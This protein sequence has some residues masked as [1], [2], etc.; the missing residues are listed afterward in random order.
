MSKEF[1]SLEISNLK[2]ESSGRVRAGIAA[3]HGNV[4]AWD[5]RSHPGAFAKTL[6]ENLKRVKHLWNHNS[7]MPP[8]ASITEIKEIGID[9]IP[10]E[11]LAKFQPGVI[12]GGLKVWREYYENP[13][14]DWVL[15][16]IDKGDITEMSYAYDAVKSEY[17]DEEIPTGGKRRVRD[18]LEVK[19]YETSDVLWGMNSATSANVK[20]YALEMM[21]LGSIYQQIQLHN[22]QIKAGRRNSESDSVLISQIHDLAKSLGAVC[23]KTEKELEEETESQSATTAKEKAEAA[24]S[25]SLN[26]NWFELQKSKIKTLEF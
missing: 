16:G 24:K 8:I 14:A 13:L 25:T 12:T 21:P 20:G 19:L 11:I 17:A 4:D 2:A 7:S 1:K 3:V 15:E 23:E 9:E 18:L 10:A 26:S 5:D 6:A 22:E